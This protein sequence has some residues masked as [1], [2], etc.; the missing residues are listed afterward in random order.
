MDLKLFTEMLNIDSTS[1]KE[2]EF[3]DFLECRLATGK[4]SVER[5]DVGD[6][7]ANLLFSWGTPEI[8]FCTHMDTVPPY[9]PPTIEETEDGDSIIKGRGSCDAKGQIFSMY[10]ACLEL[11]KEGCT[12]FGLLLLS[13]EETGSFGARHFS[14]SHPGYKYVIVGEPT[15]NR[16]TSAS[17]GTKA[18]EV[19]IKGKSCHSGYPQFGESAVNRF[20]DFANELKNKDFAIDPVLGETT[21]N[22]GRLQSENP[23]NVLSDRLVFR[24]YFR[25]TFYSDSQVCE[26]ME[27]KR[28][29]DIEITSFGGDTPSSYLTL[30]GFEKGTVAFGSDAPQ[31][32]N[33][34]KKILYGPGS[35][36]VAHTA[37]E[38]IKM[39]E[40]ETARNNYIRI[41]H[42]LANKD[43][44]NI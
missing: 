21:W 28:C 2:A 1:S 25:T 13:G 22:I 39:S 44:T 40:L 10:S 9:I 36:L 32:K 6:G 3:A 8:M 12:G 43:K 37:H 19:T 27:N 42:L 11:E 41:F 33:F 14:K 35:I 15:D 17:K 5:F 18:F 34:K 4:C 26:Y 29:E 24:T 31:L 20:V 30:D 23:Q 7:T 38:H 16:M